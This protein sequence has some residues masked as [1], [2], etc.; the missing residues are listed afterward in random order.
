[1]AINITLK[2]QYSFKVF[3][4]ITLDRMVAPETQ[5]VTGTYKIRE[6]FHNLYFTQYC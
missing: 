6:E 4:K 5:E 1:M 3:G 2:V